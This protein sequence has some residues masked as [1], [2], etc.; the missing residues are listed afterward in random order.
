M[1]L[2]SLLPNVIDT[3]YPFAYAINEVFVNGRRIDEVFYINRKKGLVRAYVVPR[4]VHK[5]KK[6]LLTK[7][8]YGEIELI[9]DSSFLLYA[10]EQK[11]DQQ[12]VTYKDQTRT[13]ITILKRRLIENENLHRLPSVPDTEQ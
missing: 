12:R 1:I 2:D 4:K 7:T 3:N 11:Q 6:R 9:L 10:I 5:H 8:F 13:E